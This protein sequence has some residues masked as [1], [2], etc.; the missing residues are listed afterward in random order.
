M[1][2]LLV[3]LSALL[4]LDTLKMRARL[5]ALPVLRDAGAA[6]P[7]APAFHVVKAPGVTVDARTRDAAIAF[8]RAEGL[9]VV[10][11]VPRDLPAIRAMTLAQLVDPRRYRRD[12]L[13]PGRTAGHALVLSDDVITRAGIDPKA[14]VPDEVAFVRLAVRAKQYAAARADL[15]VAPA[16]RAQRLDPSQRRAVLASI[17][18]PSLPVAFAMFPAFWTIMGLGLWLEPIA[19]IVAIALWHL[20]PLLAIGG[21]RVRPRDLLLVTL[22]RAPVEAWL[23]VR[24]LFGPGRRAVTVDEAA[25]RRT[26]YQELLAQGTERFFEPRRE[27]CPLCDG[28]D[29]APHVRAPDLLQQKPGTFTL[30][31]CAGCGHVFQNPRLS[32]DGLDFYYRDFYDGLG[33]AGMEF[34]FGFGS[35]QYRDRAAMVRAHHAPARWLDVGAGHGHF[36]SVARDVLPETRF[37]GLD[38]STSIDEAARRGWIDRGYRALFPD[39]A[40]ELAGAY[41]TISMSH[42]LEHTRDPAAELDAAHTVLAP[43]GH[44]LIEVPD[45]EFVL[46]RWLGRYW[47]PWFQP[48]HQHLVSVGNLEKLLRARGFTP[49]EWHRGPAHQRVDF[50]FAAWLLLQRLGPRTKLPWRWR[51]AGGQLRRAVVWSVGMPLVVGGLVLDRV[52]SPLVRRSARSNTYRVVAR[53]DG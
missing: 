29:L 18:G 34:I 28:R 46:G 44:L 32:L 45:P 26:A 42:Y 15:A 27:T 5:S 20:Q 11:L 25:A 12:R 30:E 8:A 2:W 40:P 24:T 53:K 47:L 16:A 1:I 51:G 7:D 14:A 50:F 33:E 43:G 19:A 13:A 17:L 37:D 52:W 38:L 22:A 36:C 3:A 31:R 10:D 41:D 49:L 39:K 23:L 35:G 9:D 6:A 4:F 48:Q 21:T